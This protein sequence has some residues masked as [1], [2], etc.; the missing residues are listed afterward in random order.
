MRARTARGSARDCHELPRS[1][2]C[3]INVGCQ[4][5][6]VREDVGEYITDRLH[7]E[8]SAILVDAIERTLIP[9]AFC[10]APLLFDAQGNCWVCD[11]T[12]RRW[13]WE[14]GR[15]NGDGRVN[16]RHARNACE[17][18][19]RGRGVL[20]RIGTQDDVTVSGGGTDRLELVGNWVGHRLAQT[21]QLFR[22][23]WSYTYL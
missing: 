3:P 2:L 8:A 16:R 11:L 13:W 21:L 1:N 17:L 14:I 7:A 4:P 20:V 10:V 5:G 23:E 12:W 18:G 9:T 22:G 6:V 15:R 19:D